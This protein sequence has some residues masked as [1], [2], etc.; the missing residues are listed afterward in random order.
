M[1]M[2]HTQLGEVLD[3]LQ[4]EYFSSKKRIDFIKAF[5]RISLRYRERSGSFLRTEEE[6]MAYLFT[7]LP[8]TFSAV[9]KVFEEI[10]KRCPDLSPESFLDVGAGP[11]TGMWAALEI[12]ETLS[13]YTL[14]EKDLEFMSMGK[15]LAGRSS[16]T[17]VQKANWKICDLE[18]SLEIEPHDLLL[19]SYSI[20]E[21]KEEFLAPLLSTLWRATGKALI[22]VEPGTP[23][24]YLKLMK[25]RDLLKGMGGYIWA[26]CPHSLACPLSKG[27][28]CH[29]SVRVQRSSLHRQLKSGDLGYEDEKFSYLIFGKEPISSFQGRILRHPIKHPGHMEI[30]ACKKEGV[31]KEIYSKKNKEQYKQMKKLDW[32][33]FF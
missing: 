19:L 32:G 11:G 16:S 4:E 22:I 3:S 8:G 27:D 9:S 21:I 33:D 30:V 14:L 2:I 13:K 5:E 10:K 15:D 26:P 29:F 23:V 28:W 12:F 6:R 20:G 24:G 18:K 17:F 7:R 31:Q 1:S 25:I